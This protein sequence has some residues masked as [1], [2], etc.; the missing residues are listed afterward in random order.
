MAKIPDMTDQSQEIIWQQQT[1]LVR[2]W[3]RKVRDQLK[4]S[5]SQFQDGKRVMAVTYG[6][7]KT[8]TKGAARTEYKLADSLKH[9]VLYDNQV[10]EGTSFRLQRHGVF[11]HYGVGRGYQR[12]NG[13]VM[14]IKKREDGS[15]DQRDSMAMRRRPVDWFNPV[16]DH[17]LPELVEKVTQINA[18]AVVNAIRMKIQ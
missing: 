3:S 16:I 4:G 14:R 6:K 9:R 7:G 18:D 11:L 1:D 10:A 17:N 12:I 13:K 2:V 5:A 8:I 15:P